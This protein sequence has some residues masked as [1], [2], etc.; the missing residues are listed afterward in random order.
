MAKPGQIRLIQ[1]PQDKARVSFLC[2]ERHPAHRVHSREVQVTEQAAQS[3]ASQN[4]PAAAVLGPPGALGLLVPATFSL[5]GLLRSQR[6][7]LPELAAHASPPWTNAESGL[8][9]RAH[10]GSALLGQLSGPD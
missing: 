6:Q 1:S 9:S 5:A 8:L 4:C 10:E 2:L 3:A 7:S